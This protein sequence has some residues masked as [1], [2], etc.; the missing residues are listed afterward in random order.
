MFAR[1]RIGTAISCV[2]SSGFAAWF[3]AKRSV[4]VAEGA[5]ER[6]SAAA[7]LG[8]GKLVPQERAMIP[9]LQKRDIRAARAA[10][11]TKQQA[12]EAELPERISRPAAVC[13]N[14]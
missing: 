7:M 8:N 6:A 12:R 14:E 11:K 2:F 3:F 10:W 1:D 4:R 5:D 9:L 13:Q